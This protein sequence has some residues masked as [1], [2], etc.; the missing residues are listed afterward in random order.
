MLLGVVALYLGNGR[1][2]PEQPAFPPLLLSLKFISCHSLQVFQLADG[3]VDF[4]DF[5]ALLGKPVPCRT[6]RL[7]FNRKRKTGF[8]LPHRLP[9]I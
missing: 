9:R 8:R 4:L 3:L 2:Q 6:G 5:G 7:L 1:P